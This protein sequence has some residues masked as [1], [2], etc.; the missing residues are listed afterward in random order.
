MKPLSIDVIEEG[1]VKVVE[2]ARELIEDAE[3]LMENGRA[4]RAYCLAYLAYEEL[5]KIPVLI[6]VLSKTLRGISIDWGSVGKN[7]FKHYRKFRM[8]SAMSL[9]VELR[10]RHV[11]NGTTLK[12]IGEMFNTMP[13]YSHKKD[14]SLYAGVRDGKFVK[15]SEV[16][17]DECAEVMIGIAR[18]VLDYVEEEEEATQGKS[19][20]IARSPEYEAFLDEMNSSLF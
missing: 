16:I 4:A 3:L 19:E 15:P 6:E 12:R 18:S 13:D 14:Y 9:L 5:A 20:E 2:N 17:S 10:R 11:G 8:A 7:L 1:R